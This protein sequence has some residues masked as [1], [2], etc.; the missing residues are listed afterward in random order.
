MTT[1]TRDRIRRQYSH[2]G[3][4]YDSVRIDSER[5]QIL[6]N[7]DLALFERLFPTLPAGARLLQVGA[8]TGRFSLS[9]LQKGH[10]LVACDVNAA[11]LET[12]ERKVEALGFAARC[13]VRE[14]DIFG[15][16]FPDSAFDLVFCIHVV[17]RFT[18]PEDQHAALL[19]LCRVTKPGGH[20]LVNYRNRRSPYNLV[21]RG[22]S[23]KP[24][25]FR[26]ALGEGGLRIVKQ[27][28]KHFLNG[29]LIERLPRPLR[30][31]VSAVDRALESVG[32][33]WAWDLFVLAEKLRQP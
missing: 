29:T 9:A 26:A 25:Q 7:H 33:S 3:D 2:G 14:E 6:T 30:P 20:L 5:G 4:H 15:L 23:I 27:R 8:G 11:Q 24:A 18:T 12:L 28:T 19:E 22:A 10:S 1:E 17:P 13:E 31:V 16:S 21:Y 32:P